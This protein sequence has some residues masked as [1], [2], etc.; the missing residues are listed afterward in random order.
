M[1]L[2]K[3]CFLCLR[4]RVQ[5]LDKEGGGWGGLHLPAGS[6]RPL[7]MCVQLGHLLRLSAVVKEAVKMVGSAGTTELPCQRAPFKK[8]KTAPVTSGRNAEQR[9]FASHTRYICSH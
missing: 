6:I 8:K 2:V 5:V 7:Q 1:T 4:A 9:G 3:Q